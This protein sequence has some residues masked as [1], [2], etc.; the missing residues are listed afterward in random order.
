M[1]LRLVVEGIVVAIWASGRVCL[2]LY[3]D[4][5]PFYL[6]GLNLIQA[7]IGNHMPCNV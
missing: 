5:G 4:Q 6:H 3:D 2:T 1:K 7:W